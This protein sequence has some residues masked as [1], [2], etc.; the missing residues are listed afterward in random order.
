[1]LSAWLRL[2]DPEN[3]VALEVAGQWAGI[4]EEAFS[5]GS[6]CRDREIA[7]FTRW[8]GAGQKASFETG[9]GMFY[10]AALLPGIKTR[11]TE[12]PLFLDYY[13]SKP[14]GMYYTYEQ[15]LKQPPAVCASRAASRYLAAMEVLLRYDRA[16]DKLSF[17]IDWLDANRDENGQWDFGEKAK[18]GVYFPL[19]D[20]WDQSSRITDSSYRVQNFLAA[21][22]QAPLA[23]PCNTLFLPAT[24]SADPDLRRCGTKS[25]HYRRRKTQSR[26]SKRIQ[27][28]K[29]IGIFVSAA[30]R[31]DPYRSNRE[32]TPWCTF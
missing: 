8:R 24:S 23:S 21:W 12:A 15:V 28:L 6:Y 25:C 3:E 18:D 17:V 29:A 16:R 9:F 19:S 7:A 20:R 27:G 10:H 26:R 32:T 11:E 4:V 22:N 2:F 13:L 14:D 30:S 31:H 5:S 1:M